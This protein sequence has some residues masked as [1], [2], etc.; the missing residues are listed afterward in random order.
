MS[1]NQFNS[2]LLKRLRVQH[3][4]TLQQVAAHLGTSGSYAWELENGKPEPSGHKVFL[5][6][7]LFATP[8]ED[9]YIKE[10]SEP[11][12]LAKLSNKIMFLLNDY[13]MDELLRNASKRKKPKCK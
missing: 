4:F 1:D 10:P 3:G 9:F 5:L 7:R 13:Q 8:M 12:E 11:T 6:S 2:N